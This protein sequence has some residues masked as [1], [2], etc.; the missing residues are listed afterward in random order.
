MVGP[1][2]LEHCF[3]F[4]SAHPVPVRRVDGLRMRL[5]LTR[6]TPFPRTRNQLVKRKQSSLT[7][8]TDRSPADRTRPYYFPRES[9]L[10]S[11][12]PRP[13]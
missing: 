13:Q 5:P 10:L 8:A 3:L 1:R 6:V 2:L 4:F 9:R 7:L 12:R 11:S